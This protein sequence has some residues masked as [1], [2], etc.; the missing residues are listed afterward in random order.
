MIFLVTLVLAYSITKSIAIAK[1]YFLVFL[2]DLFVMGLVWSGENLIKT[3]EGHKRSTCKR[4]NSQARCLAQYSLS[5]RVTRDLDSWLAIVA[6]D[7]RTSLV[8][9]KIVTFRIL[10]TPT[11]YTLITYRNGKEP[12][13]KKNP[14]RG[15]YNTPTLLDRE[16]YSFLERNICNL[17]SFPLLLLYPLKGDSY[18]N[19]THTHL[20]CWECF[21][22]LGSIGRCQ[23]WRM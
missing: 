19:T 4:V 17:F 15:F 6:S 11:I 21:S 1:I 8:L 7:P 23:R 16:S 3:T 12:I 10:F 13:E 9:L 2:W 14:I 22:S 20:E 5:K 18:P